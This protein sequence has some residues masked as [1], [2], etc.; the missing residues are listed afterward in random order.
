MIWSLQAA[1]DLSDRQFDLWSK[2]LEERAGICL[3]DAQRIF[4]QT[5]I[6]MRMRELGQS[7]YTQYYNRVID[8]VSGMM[9]W[10]VLIDRLVVKETSF[11]R[12]LP[13][14]N[15]VQEYLQHKINN[16]ELDSSFEIWSVGCSSG[17]E[18][19]TLSMVMNETFELARLEPYFGIIASDIS[20]AALAIARAG[21]YPKRKVEMV[22]APIRQR[23]FKAIEKGRYQISPEV[24]DRVCF[25]QAN[26]LNINEFPS[27]ELDVIF[28]QN[29]L[30]Y[31]RRELRHEIMDAFVE[32]LK[33]GGILICG[34]GEVVDWTN[35][36]ISRIAVGGVQV[37]VRK[38]AQ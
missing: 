18:P 25:N 17:E 14:V 24:V 29:L 15:Y 8:G 5:Q 13:S 11:F 21:I 31:F 2:L 7:D 26:V 36:E 35:K 10:S 33:P 38:T 4:L 19:Y 37:Y 34:L 3:G 30:I 32:R 9:E 16:S 1:P 12:H 23:Y 27:I 28:C 20:R 6:S 22:D